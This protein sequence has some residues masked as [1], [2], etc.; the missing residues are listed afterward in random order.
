VKADR[1]TAF[2]IPSLDGIRA[3]SFLVVFV[4]H[5]G[6]GDR[7]PGGFGVTVFF[8]LSGYLITTL[9]RM[10]WEARGTLSLKQFYLRRALRILPPFY[11][12]L[13]LATA[14]AGLGLLARGFRPSAVVAQA[15]HAFNYWFILHPTPGEPPGTSV[16]WSLAVE[17]HFYLFFPLAF[18]GL[19]RWVGA[20]GRRAAILYAA[21]AAIL[22]WRLVLVYALHATASRTYMGSDTRVDS[23][24]YGCALA[25]YGNPVID[26]PSRFSER[27]WKWAILPVSLGVLLFTF[28]YRGDAFR[29]TARYSLQGVAL[30]PLF[31]TSIRYP[32][33][34]PYRALNTRM[35]SFIGVLSYSL[36]LVHHV[37]LLAVQ[38]HLAVDPVAQAVLSL[39]L[40]IG[41]AWTIYRLV[42]KPCAALRRRLSRTKAQAAGPGGDIEPAR[43]ERRVAP[44]EAG[45]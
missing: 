18:I 2:H 22:L 42:E 41:V 6:L 11:L 39:A 26:G 32:T 3:A 21:C 29:E 38:A 25:V 27:W 1:A 23:I 13:G 4:A 28:V 43:V 12:T 9:M 15:L 37:I 33:W 20:P 16:Y 5:A 10:E 35:A 36:Y 17:E 40:S 45:S 19:R 24:L 31:I 30:A 44:A 7:I 14:A 34:L 8:F